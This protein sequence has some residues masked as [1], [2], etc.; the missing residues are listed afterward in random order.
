MKPTKRQAPKNSVA[1]IGSKV[2][3]SF[4]VSKI[5]ENQLKIP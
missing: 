1:G 4:N 2:F 3:A 5:P